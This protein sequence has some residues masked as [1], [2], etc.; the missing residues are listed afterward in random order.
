VV[1]LGEPHW[2]TLIGV[3]EN[4]VFV[5]DYGGIYKIPIFEFKGRVRMHHDVAAAFAP[6]VAIYVERGSGK[7]RPYCPNDPVMSGITH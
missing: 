3:H 7:V 2:V 6:G 5:I 4:H 1:D